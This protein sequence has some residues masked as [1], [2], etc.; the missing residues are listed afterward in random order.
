M[1]I[2]I[3][4]IILFLSIFLLHKV[5]KSNFY[6]S[7]YSVNNNSI[8]DNTIVSN[9]SNHLEFQ[10]DDDNSFI[11]DDIQGVDQNEDDYESSN[12]NCL[13]TIQEKISTILCDRIF[14]KYSKVV[15]FKSRVSKIYILF[16][17]FRI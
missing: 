4:F 15:S 12:S 5:G 2:K 3:K 16:S 17:V 1:K 11:Q 9:L 14:S 6:S 7:T 8:V 13:Y 10:D